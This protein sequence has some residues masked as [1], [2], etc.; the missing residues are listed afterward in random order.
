MVIYINGC[1]ASKKD[2]ALLIERCKQ[3]LDMITNVRTTN[4]G[5]LSVSTI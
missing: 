3:G 1:K 5:F 2:L 4:R